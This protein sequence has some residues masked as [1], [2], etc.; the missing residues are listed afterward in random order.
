MTRFAFPS[1]RS[2]VPGG[3]TRT[4][5]VTP[6]CALMRFSAFRFERGPRLLPDRTCLGP[7][8]DQSGELVQTLRTR[9]FQDVV[10]RTETFSRSNCKD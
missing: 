7:G 3:T 10:R 2:V 6:I 8:L 4:T 1:E 9:H 5:Q